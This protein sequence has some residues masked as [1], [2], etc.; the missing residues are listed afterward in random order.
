MGMYDDPLYAEK[1]VK[2]TK[3]RVKRVTA[4]I[5][6]HIPEKKIKSTTSKAQ[7]APQLKHEK[8][9]EE[10]YAEIEEAEAE[11]AA[12]GMPTA[13]YCECKRFLEE[14]ENVPQYRTPPAQSEN[15]HVKQQTTS[16]GSV[17]TLLQKIVR[18]SIAAAFI[19]FVVWSCIEDTPD[20]SLPKDDVKTVQDENPDSN[21]TPVK[22]T[23]GQIVTAPDGDR[24]APLEI[25][26]SGN[27]NYYI[28]LSPV[29]F[30]A[31]RNGAMSFYLSGKKL[32]TDVPIGEYEIYCACGD[33]WYGTE[34]K[35]GAYT[36]YFKFDDTFEFSEDEDG[37]YGWTLTL[38]KVSNGN[39]S[40]DSIGADDFPNI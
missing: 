3:L 15:Y 10:I 32:E 12:A 16:K 9:F 35:F 18:L 5:S 39:L 37:T 20:G 8:T 24:I 38:Y 22:I 6:Q 25:K 40:T 11:A 13:Q 34:H 19:A 21:L 7:E 2:Y 4:K 29:D 17:K 1:K 30:E 33:T 31:R 28:V 23:N 26:S 36:S 14:R 27:D